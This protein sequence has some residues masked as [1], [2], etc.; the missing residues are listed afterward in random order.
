LL[1]TTNKGCHPEE[2][3]ATKDL[4][5]VFMNLQTRSFADAQ[6]DHQNQVL[7]FVQDDN[8]NQVLHFVQDDRE[9]S[10]P[11]NTRPVFR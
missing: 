7:H 8:K 11:S 4:E 10:I 5:W 2:P 9:R 3:Q 1:R 6:D